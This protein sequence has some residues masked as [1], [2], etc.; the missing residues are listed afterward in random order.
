[1]P[2]RIISKIDEMRQVPV[3]NLPRKRF[4][5]RFGPAKKDQRG[6]IRRLKIRIS[7]TMS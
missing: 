1:M 5:R 2:K 6:T 4:E 7:C 3:D